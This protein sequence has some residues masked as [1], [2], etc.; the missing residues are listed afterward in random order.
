MN[1]TPEQQAVGR[2]NFLKAVAGVPA[3][4]GLGAAAAVTGPVRGGPVRVG[5]I[6][7]GGEGR[8]LLAQTDPAYAEV[9]ALCDINPAQL[10]LA[11]EVLAKTARPAA[12]HVVE[13]KELIA[14][15][16]IEAVIVATPL[17]SHAEIASACLE[18]GK[19]VLCEKMMAWDLA[20]CVR[21]R[22]AAA[23]S[24]RLLEIGYQRCY[25]QVYQAAYEGIVKAG[26]LG[27]I[28]LARLA[29]HRNGNW[30]R[31]GNPPSPDYDPSKWGYPTWEHLLNWRLYTRYSRGLLAE[32]GSHQVNVANWF[33][34]STPEA[35]LGTGGIHR[36]KDGREV[37]DHAVRDVRVSRRPDGGLL[38]HRIERVRFQ[39]RGVFRHQGHAGAAWGVG[40]LPVRRSGWRP[41]HRHRRRPQ[42]RRT[43]PRS[44]REPDRGRRRTIGER[45]RGTAGRS[46]PGLQAADLGLLRRD[47]R[48]RSPRLWSRQSLAI[49]GG[50]PARGRGGPGEDA[51]G[52]QLF[53]YV[54][55]D[56]SLG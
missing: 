51:S 56:G 23:K 2:R 44:V 13:W 6:G 14:R 40:G 50:L 24:G 10:G 19:H 31:S 22:D 46:A 11:D 33:F 29:W 32:L 35:V 17:W 28:Y 48:R 36:F 3:L 41:A 27:E 47:S 16:D 4:A 26:G 18:A 42:D 9:V 54:D 21:M 37:F 39:L 12:T 34:D 53:D 8:V 55:G 43:R 7:L 1:L 30:R 25:N 45:H 20:G 52:G 49:G 38:D 15:A 5:V